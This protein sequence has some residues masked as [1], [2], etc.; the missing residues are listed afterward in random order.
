[1]I[2]YFVG[3]F[4]IL[5]FGLL[6]VSTLAAYGRWYGQTPTLKYEGSKPEGNEA[7]LPQPPDQ[8]Q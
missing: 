3:I 1:M 4:G 7:P 2:G 5:T 8:N 6:L